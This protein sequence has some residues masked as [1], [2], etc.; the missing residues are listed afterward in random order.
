MNLG[1]YIPYSHTCFLHIHVL[2]IDG[3]S[4]LFIKN[5]L[6][7]IKSLEAGPATDTLVKVIYSERTLQG[8]PVRDRGGRAGAKQRCSLK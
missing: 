6:S 1:V 5:T 7:W 3:I 4:F 8:N 2:P